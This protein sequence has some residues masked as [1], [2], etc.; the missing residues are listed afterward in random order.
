VSLLIDRN[1]ALIGFMTAGK[2]QVGA[3]LGRLIGRPFV[4]VDQL[5]EG[6]ERASVEE[7]FR[8]HGEAYFRGLETTILRQLC[9]G[10][11]QIIGCGGG[12]VLSEE[13]RNCL[14]ERCVTV[15][16]KVSQPEVL[17]RLEQ[18]G[19]PRRPL[20]EG[21]S[22]IEVVPA[23][24]KSRM[25]LY[26]QADCSVDTDGRAVEEIAREITL[27]LGLP[28]LAEEGDSSGAP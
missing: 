27:R 10:S 20:L 3:C 16:L 25:P 7:I 17:A 19:S 4:D 1:I 21:V 18:P 12:T 26:A 24:L 2:T 15:W 8:R 23:L 13:N 6:L 14:K 22:P 9:Q 11:G 5:I 28:V